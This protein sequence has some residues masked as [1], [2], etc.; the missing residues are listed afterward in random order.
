MAVD[1]WGWKR[2]RGKVWDLLASDDVVVSE[3]VLEREKGEPRRGGGNSTEGRRVGWVVAFN[4]VGRATSEVRGRWKAGERSASSP[5]LKPRLRTRRWLF[6][7]ERR[8][9]LL[10]KSCSSKIEGRRT[11]PLGESSSSRECWARR[12]M[13][14]FNER[15]SSKR[16]GEPRRGEVV[17][18]D[19][20]RGG[21]R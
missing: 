14:P 21:E 10:P 8:D 18:W 11:A 19:W 5:R 13:V 15:A 17:E 16:T 4:P 7:T 3:V 12:F 2:R 9:A 1:G 20:V 6:G